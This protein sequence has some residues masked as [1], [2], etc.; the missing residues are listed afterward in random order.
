MHRHRFRAALVVDGLAIILTPN[1]ELNM[2]TVV[3]VG[4]KV[5]LSVLFF[6]QN[7]NPMLTAP[8]PDSVAWANSNA[9]AETLVSSGT[10]AV[11][12]AIAPGTDQISLE[13]VVAGATFSATLAVEV[14]AAAQV[15]TSVSI[16][17]VVS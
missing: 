12:T 9:A 10:T 1:Q 14:D 7:G 8:T 5:N 13:V 17:A 2:A 16:E 6:D 15:L 11:A 3:N 4:H